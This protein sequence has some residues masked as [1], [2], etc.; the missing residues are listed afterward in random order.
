MVVVDNRQWGIQVD[1]DLD[2]FWYFPSLTFVC[3][4]F[5]I[6]SQIGICI[7]IFA[8]CEYKSRVPF[9]ILSY[10][11]SS[12]SVERKSNSKSFWQLAFPRLALDI[13]ERCFSVIIFS[14]LTSSRSFAVEVKRESICMYANHYVIKECLK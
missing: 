1:F 8:S 4:F 2:Q 7:F 14:F 6:Y 5:S 10:N 13:F 3:L 9:N 12:V 11:V